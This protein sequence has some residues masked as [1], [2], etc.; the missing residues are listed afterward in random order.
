[1]RWER[2]SRDVR[3]LVVLWVFADIRPDR[4]DLLTK[5]LAVNT[6]Y[7]VLGSWSAI[8]LVEK[9]RIL[10]AHCLVARCSWPLFPNEVAKWLALRR[11]GMFGCLVAHHVFERDC[12]RAFVVIRGIDV[13]IKVV[14]ISVRVALGGSGFVLWLRPNDATVALSGLNRGVALVHSSDTYICMSVSMKSWR[15]HAE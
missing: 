5:L 10:L 14:G 13:D 11:P 12:G 15:A 8:V 4:L 6:W 9:T 2:W 7:H 1:M 3:G